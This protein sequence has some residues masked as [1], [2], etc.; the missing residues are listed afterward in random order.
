VIVC[1]P[2][3]ATLDLN[4]FPFT[5]GPDHDPPVGLSPLKNILSPIQRSVSVN[6]SVGVGKAW[7]VN[8]SVSCA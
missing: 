6:E 4:L 7:T 2:I 1:V 3:P 5:P 8:T